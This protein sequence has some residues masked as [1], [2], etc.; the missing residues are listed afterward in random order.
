MGDYGCNT[1]CNRNVGTL[2]PNLPF[3][4]QNVG[5]IVA[6]LNPTI[7]KMIRVSFMADNIHP[8]FHRFLTREDKESLLGQRGMVIW[9]TGLSGA[10]KSTIANAVERHFYSI[11]RMTTILDG[12]NLRTGLNQ[13]LGFSDVERAENIRR[14]AEVAKLFAFQGIITIVSLI[15]PKNAFRQAARSIIGT[16]Y[17]EV[18]IHA[19]FENCIK[20]DPKGLYK[21]ALDGHVPHFTGKDSE[22]EMPESAQLV[23]DTNA[24]SVDECTT[25]LIAY[26]TKQL[27]GDSQSA[28][29]TTL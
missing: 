29:Q 19:S 18:F 28:A 8:E 12:D 27:S 21:K 7:R 11:G 26:I 20:R 15:T 25:K 22:F 17:H 4:Q 5:W 3:M 14:T 23:L 13:D 1:L 6:C 2:L 9:M 16:E 24:H 10:G